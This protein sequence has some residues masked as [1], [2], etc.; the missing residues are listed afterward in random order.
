MGRIEQILFKTV[1]ERAR[2]YA[3]LWDG[4]T[5]MSAGIVALDLLSA[6]DR[7]KALETVKAR[8]DI[9]KRIEI[10]SKSPIADVVGYMK[11][12]SKDGNIDTSFWSDA[13]KCAFADLSEHV[14]PGSVSLDDPSGGK[15]RFLTEVLG[16][17]PDKHDA[18]FEIVG[19]W[20]A[21]EKSTQPKQKKGRR[22]PEAG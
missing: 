16:V 6:E 22:K 15:A 7:E 19:K 5:A 3:G 4:K 14:G 8:D 13:D 1:W 2:Y 9:A 21:Q 11:S 20:K 10:S 12:I 18:F 17:P